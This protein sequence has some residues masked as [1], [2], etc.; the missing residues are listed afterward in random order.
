MKNLFSKISFAMMLAFTFVACNNEKG[1]VIN[2]VRWATRNVD[3]PG[4]FAASPES[5]GMFYQWNSKVGWSSTYPMINSNGETTW[6]SSDSD[7]DYW[8]PANDPCP[9]GWRVPTTSEYQS[10]VN[11][12]SIWTTLNGVSGRLFGS[13]PNFV[14]L[15]AAGDRVSP[16]GALYAVGDTGFYW[17][18]TVFILNNK[19]LYEYM[20]FGGGVAAAG[21]AAT[22]RR[23]GLSVRCVAE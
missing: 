8:M 20:S 10:L 15:P 13:T 16:D 4:T 11:S 22:N 23:D 9:T 5:A 21:G 6:E 19:F 3:A 1:I 18:S 2:G 7:A 14:F 17:T 12:G